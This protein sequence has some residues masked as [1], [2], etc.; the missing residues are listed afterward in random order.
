MINI[1]SLKQGDIVKFRCGGQ[2]TFVKISNIEN[3]IIHF[4]GD[5]EG[6]FECEFYVRYT[7]NG[8]SHESALFDIIAIIPPKSTRMELF[9]ITERRALHTAISLCRC[10]MDFLYEGD[11]I[12]ALKQ[13]LAR[14][15]PASPAN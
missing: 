11:E 10:D 15:I 2:A 14:C 4:E 8:K 1:A 5:F 9:T 13:E 7:T 12:E 3:S 6:D